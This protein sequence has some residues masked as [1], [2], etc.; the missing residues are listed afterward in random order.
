[1]TTNDFRSADDLHDQRIVEDLL[2][3]TGMDHPSDAGGLKPALMHVRSIT[4]GPQPTP[5]GE[6]AVLLARLDT[7]PTPAPGT[8]AVAGLD[9]R[10]RRRHTR[11]VIAATALSLALGAGAAAAAAVN[12]GFRDGV[13]KTV[14]TLVNALTSGPNDR[15]ADTP[16]PPSTTVPV[17]A[18]PGQPAAPGTAASREPVI[19]P[20][21]AASTPAGTLPDP[22]E[23]G[24]GH[25]APAPAE[26]T[27]APPPVP[28]P[29][30]P[31][32]SAAPPENTPQPL[33]ATGSHP[34]QPTGRR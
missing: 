21:P 28:A 4:H 6:L 24:M 11:M 16:K 10:R 15:S 23:A 19:P 14:T 27:F 5:R 25:P 17:T 18:S 33:P 7:G 1:M 2:T 31:V 3:E 26:P 8:G 29:S 13:Q 9:D 30:R 20:V 22:G 12:P 34:T 32:A